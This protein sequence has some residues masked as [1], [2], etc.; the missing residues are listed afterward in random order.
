MTSTLFARLRL[1]AALV[2]AM[3]GLA[4]A[5]RAAESESEPTRA[6]A[7]PPLRQLA[8]MRLPRPEE[9]MILGAVR[10]GRRVIAVGDRGLVL[11]SDDGG[12]TYRQARDVPTRATLTAVW[13]IDSSTLWA[14]G[15]WGV[16]LVSHDAARPGRS[17]AATSRAINR[18]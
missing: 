4:Q 13:A 9:G 15:H 2:L 5:G 14:V 11:L 7:V 16:M 8:A 6:V 10:A 3:T 1:A 12:K 17:S 18:C